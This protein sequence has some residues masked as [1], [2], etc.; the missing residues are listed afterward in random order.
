MDVSDRFQ[1]EALHTPPVLVG[2]AVRQLVLD[3]VDGQDDLDFPVYFR[4][5][6]AVA[7][8]VLQTVFASR[9]DQVVPLLHS[10]AARAEQRSIQDLALVSSLKVVDMERTCTQGSNRGLAGPGTGDNAQ[11]SSGKRR[12]R[13]L[14][15]SWRASRRSRSA[16]RKANIPRP[17]KA[18]LE[19]KRE[20][21]VGHD[22]SGTWYSDGR[23]GRWIRDVREEKTKRDVHEEV[24]DVRGCSKQQECGTRKA[25]GGNSQSRVLAPLTHLVQKNILLAGN[26]RPDPTTENMVLNRVSWLVR[27]WIW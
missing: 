23:S 6:V 1:T 3:L 15:V 27:E 10:D 18:R 4:L 24:E 19:V 5:H 20:E 13:L 9:R 2:A 8:A 7:H 26:R 21:S 11:F 14:G 25:G 22:K 17:M 16:L 12:R